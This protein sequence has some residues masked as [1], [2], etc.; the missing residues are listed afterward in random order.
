L[1]GHKKGSFTGA[2]SDKRGLFE[3]ADGGTFFLDEIADISPTIQ[4]KLLRVLQE[5]FFRRVGDT[6]DRQVDIRIV[7]ATN[8]ELKSEVDKGNFREDLY[9]RLNVIAITM[10][11]LRERRTD[12]PVLIQHFLVK[13]AEKS[14]QKIKK[15][16]PAAMK[17]M[18]RYDWPGNVRE[19]ENTIERA[20]VLAGDRNITLSDLLIPEAGSRS[21]APKTLKDQEKE[22]VLKTLEE[23]EGNKTR[24]ADVLGVSLRWLHYKLSEWNSNKSNA[25]LED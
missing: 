17:A 9:Y 14:G 8:K 1:F 12:I 10:P 21:L 18:S 7:S 20:V 4:A 3:I 13:I 23:C 5:G 24:T 19:L 25:Q 6:E 11:P 15:I 2:I 16:E 22:I